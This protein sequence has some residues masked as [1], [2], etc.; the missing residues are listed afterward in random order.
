MGD[1][2][3]EREFGDV[4]DVVRAYRLVLEHGVPG[5]PYKVATGG[6]RALGDA[7]GILLELA[8]VN[9]EVR[10][11]PAKIRPA[12]PPLLTGSAAKL[13]RLVG[14]K[15]EHRLED[16]LAEVLDYWR[17]RVSPTAPENRPSSPDEDARR[18]GM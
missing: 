10:I 13:T 11:E 3:L 18:T 6:A 17:A 9:M 7:L 2:S 1:L 4:R 14:W 12:D 15:P 5:E 8:R 16:T